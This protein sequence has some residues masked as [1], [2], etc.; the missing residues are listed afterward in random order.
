MFVK[1]H[2]DEIYYYK[3]DIKEIANS[4]A[5]N[6]NECVSE[7]EQ[8]DESEMVSNFLQLHTNERERSPS[9][10]NT[11]ATP[12]LDLS[13]L[14]EQI[15]FSEPIP[16]SSSWAFSE[17]TETMP[18]QSVASVRMLLSP[19]NSIIMTRRIFM[20]TDIQMIPKDAEAKN[21][22]EQRI[23]QISK[24]INSLKKKIKKY[25]EDFENQNGYRPS[26]SDKM[27]DKQIKKF[28][29]DLNKL[30]KELKQLKD[31]PLTAMCNAVSRP[32][33]SGDS[34]KNRS[35]QIKETLTEVEQVKIV[36]FKL[37]NQ[38]FYNHLCDF[39]Y[40]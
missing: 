9:P 38:Y 8:K 23:K 13:K 4:A 3:E 11:P 18:S 19:R 34:S 37:I 15:D 36:F 21:P 10:V 6:N 12:A 22:V 32:N 5:N 39:K 17:S 35:Q 24:Q 29:S 2:R 30:R 25:E 28:C 14:H 7:L 27:D 26:H 33:V 40:R 16:S 1:T 20:D 31:D